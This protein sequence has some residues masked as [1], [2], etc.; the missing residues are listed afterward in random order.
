M[1]PLQEITRIADPV[2]RA[3][4][5]SD[6]LAE[7]QQLVEL[8]A[9]LR[10]AAIEEAKAAG[11]TQDQIA[12]R[13]KVTPGRVSQMRRSRAPAGVV[14][15]WFL[16]PDQARPEYQLAICGSRAQ[17]TNN[18]LID[19]VV[20]ALGGLLMRHRCR[21]TNGPVGVGI[22]VLTRIADQHRPPGLDE[23]KGIF[24]HPNVVRTADYVLVVGGG[25]GTQ[26]EVDLA[27]SMGKKLLPMPTSGGTAARAYALLQHDRRLRAWMPDESFAAL[28]QADAQ[29]YTRI[30]E[31]T[32]LA[33]TT[34]KARP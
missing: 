10:R 16:P 28:E 33:S 26:A 32:M 2:E 13:L 31:E 29:A 25:Q 24:G 23:V 8:A 21:V 11:L 34:G 14:T 27:L 4:A 7:H 19:E 3:Q 20:L 9:Q 6:F 17:G 12:K 18:Q 30:V 15:G 22:E 1:D 5:L